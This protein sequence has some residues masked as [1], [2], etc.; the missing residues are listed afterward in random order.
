MNTIT[1]GLHAALLLARGRPDGLILL[2]RAPDAAMRFAARSFW[3]IGFALP[4]FVALHVMDWV[5][6][7][8][9]GSIARS[10]AQDLLGFIIGWVAFALLSHRVAEVT[11]RAALWP[12]YITAWNWCNVV[13]YLMLVVATLPALLGF[14]AWMIQTTWLVAIF[15][16]LWMEYF[17]TRLA[18]NLPK[19]MA[20]AM[21]ALDFGLGIAV[22][23]VI[24]GLN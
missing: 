24:A 14:P 9:V 12:R 15:W 22:A 18:L 16:A 20:I 10:F 23:F 5:I 1:S 11:G 21:V 13:Q 3:A 7:G 19:G 6:G 17:V 2:T 4:G 8:A